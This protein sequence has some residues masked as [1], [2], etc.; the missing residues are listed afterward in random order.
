MVRPRQFTDDELLDGARKCFIEHGPGVSTNHIA[1]EIGVSQATLF[2][3]FGT[4]QQLMVAALAPRP[5]MDILLRIEDGPTDAPIED[6]LRELASQMAGMFDRLLPCLMTLWGAGKNPHE[7]FPDKSQAPPVR[8]RK[9]MAVFFEKAQAQGRMAGGDPE[10]LAMV[11][12]GGMKEAAFQKHLLRD[13]TAKTDA[14]A[15]AAT[16]VET[17]W[18]GVQPAEAP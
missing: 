4:K 18:R 10:M 14:D 13:D 7:M 16:L 15:Y 3:R 2:K 11:F 5:N 9:A 1:D 12:I 17:F 6:Q 8:A